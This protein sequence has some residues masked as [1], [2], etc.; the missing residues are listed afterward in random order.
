VMIN[1]VH[2]LSIMD[3][4]KPILIPALHMGGSFN[5]WSWSCSMPYSPTC[6]AWWQTRPCFFCHV[7]IRFCENEQKNKG[8][9][10]KASLC[11]T[12]QLQILEMSRLSYAIR[13][14]LHLIE[15]LRKNPIS[16][17]SIENSKSFI[18]L[19]AYFWL[20]I[21]RIIGIIYHCQ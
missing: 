21:K 8:D 7:F 13:N 17:Y 18:K 6:C 2:I 20:N 11:N 5:L 1:Q 10:P 14:F 12:Q 15:F 4:I 19:V 16:L 3:G 9:F